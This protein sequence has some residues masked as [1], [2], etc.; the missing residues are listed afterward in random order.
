MRPHLLCLRVEQPPTPVDS[1]AR[2]RQRRELQVEP[3][4][5]T[6]H[7]VPEERPRL[8]PH[9]GAG[10]EGGC[11]LLGSIIPALWPSPGVHHL[12]STR[13]PCGVSSVG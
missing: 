4:L 7:V 2:L 13:A 11:A 8:V 12:T 6:S 9:I 5:R 1:T 10:P 3:S